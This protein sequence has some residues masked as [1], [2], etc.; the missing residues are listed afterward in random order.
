M[1]CL[2]L[3]RQ[4]APVAL[5]LALVRA[6]NSI[7]ARIAMI[8]ITTSSSIKVKAILLLERAGAVRGVT[9]IIAE[10]AK[11]YLRVNQSCQDASTA[12]WQAHAA[13]AAPAAHREHQEDRAAATT[14]GFLHTSCYG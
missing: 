14:A 13:F 11:G 4:A 12:R 8:A 9:R 1:I 7:A 3:L 10:F 6:G 2:S 5:S